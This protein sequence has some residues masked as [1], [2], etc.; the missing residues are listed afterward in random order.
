MKEEERKKF[1]IKQMNKKELTLEE[2]Q[3]I[4]YETEIMKFLH[5]PGIINVVNSIEDKNFIYI[6]TEL[7]SDGELF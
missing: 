4:S 5:H 3:F 1:A 2:I 6:I 7:V